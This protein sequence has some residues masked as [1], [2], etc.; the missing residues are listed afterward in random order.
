[1]NSELYMAFESVTGA[2]EYLVYNQR[3]DILFRIASVPLPETPVI[4]ESERE[5]LRLSA[6]LDHAGRWRI[7]DRTVRA[8]QP[9][10]WERDDLRKPFAALLWDDLLTPAAGP[11]LRFQPDGATIRVQRGDAQAARLIRRELSAG[12]LPHGFAPHAFYAPS[13]LFQIELDGPLSPF[14]QAL[15]CA[16]P[17]LRCGD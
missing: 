4:I 2:S 16:Y 15:I 10:V 8:G 11:A 1:M 9:V 6:T 17:M 7:Y 5:P 14:E 12:P 13:R 3:C